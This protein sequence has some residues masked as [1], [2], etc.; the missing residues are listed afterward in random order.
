[1]LEKYIE[2]F[3]RSFLP[4]GA[5]VSIVQDTHDIRI[6]SSPIIITFEIEE[7]EPSFVLSLSRFTFR[8]LMTPEMFLTTA[9]MIFGALRDAWKHVCH[10]EVPNLTLE[11]AVLCLDQAQIEELEQLL[12]SLKANGIYTA[13]LED[14]MVF[15]ELLVSLLYHYSFEID[16]VG[17]I[18]ER[19]YVALIC[20]PQEMLIPAINMLQTGLI[21][22][23][24]LGKDPQ[25]SAPP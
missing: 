19:F 17:D 20:R 10:G 2:V 7:R 16:P 1:M 15:R 13:D 18:W 5:A 22:T 21:R 8:S 12:L 11:D 25:P 6:Y 4:D 24:T 9:V 3:G 23:F 14:R